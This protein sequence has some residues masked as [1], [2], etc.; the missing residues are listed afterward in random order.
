[1]KSLLAAC[2]LLLG[3]QFG[4]FCQSRCDN[5]YSFTEVSPKYPGG[6]QGIMEHTLNKIVPLISAHYKKINETPIASLRAAVLYIN[7]KGVVMDVVITDYRITGSLRDTLCD[8]F[9]KMKGWKP[10]RQ[11]GHAVC[12]TYTYAIMCLRWQDEE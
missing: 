10:A 5:Y 12:A 7:K 3:L 1:M 11:D 4:S 2:F 6:D 8:E 9:M